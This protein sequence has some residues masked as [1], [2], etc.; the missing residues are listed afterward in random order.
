MSVTDVVVVGGGLA[1]LTAA[2]RAREAGLSAIVLERGEDERYLCNSRIASGSFN[3]AHSDPTADPAFLRQAILDD[4]EGAADPSLAE[5]LANV[6]AAAMQWF[7][8]EGAK[9]VKVTRSE[10]E[11]RWSMAP[12]RPA[13]PGFGWQGRGPD[14]ALRC[15]EANLKKRGGTIA[16][17]TK[18]TK[19]LMENGRCVGVSAVQRGEPVAFDARNVVLADGGFQGNPNLVRRFISPHPE[20]LTQRN[21]KTGRGDALIMAE[22]AGAALVGTDRFYG[23]LLVQE[24]LTNDL[25]WPYPTIDSLASSAIVVDASGRRFMDEGLGGVAMANAIAALDDPLSTV[26]IFDNTMWEITGRAEFTPPN[27]YLVSGGGTLTTADSI[28]ALAGKLGL[29]AAVVTETIRDYNAA[30]EA[31][32]FQ[33]LSPPRTPGRLFGVLRS[34]ETRTS[35][36]PIKDAPFHAIR[37]CA[38]ITYTMGGIQVDRQA[39]AID[40]NG[41]PMPGLYAAGACTGGLE[42]GPVAG[43]IGGL[44]KAL[45]MGWIAA[46][47]IAAD[48]VDAR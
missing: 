39:R 19:L 3:L 43:Y 48:V 45:T 41:A 5:A 18:A 7:R 22:E 44:C 9:F 1:G 40:R 25:L 47:A 17:G 2:N 27:P 14:Q 33:R 11:A 10:K 8:S 34:S 35:I 21:A 23:H 20:K 30:V 32:A 29:P 4:T 46:A 12:P 13:K 15:L 38:G 24:S 26:T 36:R 16:L 37:L 42:G 6:A 31:G 28:E